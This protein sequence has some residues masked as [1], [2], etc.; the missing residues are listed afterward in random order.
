MLQK[1][2]RF[3]IVTPER[4]VFRDDVLQVTVPTRQGE[5]TVLPDHIPLVAAL[6]PGVLE[7]VT[8]EGEREIMSLSGGFLE[9]LKDKVVV[10]AD[11]AEMAAEIDIDAVESARERAEETIKGIGRADAQAFS[12]ASAVIAREMARTRAHQR[13]RKFKGK[14][15]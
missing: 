10:L 1:T 8:K 4:V 14:D 6:Q 9:V 13:W 2:I 3:E 7:T 15:K 11:T 12:S 5:I